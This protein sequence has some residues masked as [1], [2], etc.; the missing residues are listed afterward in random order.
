MNS[1][2]APHPINGVAG[3]SGPSKAHSRIISA[4]REQAAPVFE[5]TRVHAANWGRDVKNVVFCGHRLGGAVG[6]LLGIAYGQVR[7]LPYVSRVISFG[8]PRVG[9]SALRSLLLRHTNHTRI[10]VRRDPV[11][12]MARWYA[13]HSAR[14]SWKERLGGRAEQRGPGE[15]GQGQVLLALWRGFVPSG[16]TL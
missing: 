2:V 16:R 14:V 3:L 15:P 13:H 10:F 1:H 8:S 5:R 12:A 7:G 11:A 9:G 6:Q 4:F